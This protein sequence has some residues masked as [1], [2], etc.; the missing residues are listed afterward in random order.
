MRRLAAVV[1]VVVTTAV[2]FACGT[3]QLPSPAYVRQPTSALREVP[4]PPPPAQVED[5]PRAPSGDAVWIDGEWTWQGR[6]WAWKAG[7]WVVPPR[8]AAF[9]P[10][11]TVRDLRGTLYFAEGTWRDPSGRAIADPKALAL[12]RPSTG[13]VVNAEG[14][15]VPTGPSTPSETEI[16]DAGLPPPPDASQLPD[17]AIRDASSEYVPIVDAS[18]PFDGAPLGTSPTMDRP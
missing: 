15:E 6:R 1:P 3:K 14:E 11:T 16:V 9:S 4:Y 7:R 5:V 10:W 18:L 17:G 13:T 2:I 8:D 12:G